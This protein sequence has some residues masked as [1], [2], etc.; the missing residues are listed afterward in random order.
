MRPPRNEKTRR[1]RVI[2]SKCA[3]GLTS[4]WSG[5]EGVEARV[6]QIADALRAGRGTRHGGER[7][8]QL[9]I[10]WLAT[11]LLLLRLLLTQILE[12]GLLR[13]RVTHPLLLPCSQPGVGVAADRLM[14]ARLVVPFDQGA[15][16]MARRHHR[17][18]G[19]IPLRGVADLGDFIE[20]GLYRLLSELL[21]RHF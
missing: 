12:H 4:R 2:R 18:V 13:V 7:W 3:A 10:R 9:N 1:G 19:E 15:I 5:R 16:G 20:R 17:P 21:V 14:G 6:A 11:T 8:R